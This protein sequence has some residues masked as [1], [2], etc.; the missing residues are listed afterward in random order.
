MRVGKCLALYWSDITDFRKGKIRVERNFSSNPSIKELSTPKTK[1]SRR[2]VHMNKH[3]LSLL[4][5]LRQKRC[6]QWLKKGH[7]EIPKWVFSASTGKP[8][9][10]WNFRRSWMR[11]QELAGVRQRHPHNLRHTFASRLLSKRVPLLYV[12]QQLGHNNPNITLT[13]YARWMP[14]ES[15]QRWVELLNSEDLIDQKTSVDCN[16]EETKG[17]RERV[18]G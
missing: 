18:S 17:Q 8:L 7:T 5:A 16:L 1:A 12:G 9:Q 6:Q 11:A 4:R 2:E 3:L 13:V 14:D 10:Y 15:D